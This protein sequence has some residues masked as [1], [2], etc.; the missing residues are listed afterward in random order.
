MKPKHLLFPVTDRRLGAY[1]GLLALVG[2]ERLLE[3]RRSRRNQLRSGP[4][5]GVAA[6]GG[7]APMVA[8]HCALFALPPL[9]ILALRRRPRSSVAAPALVALAGA[10]ALRLWAI[11]ALGSQWNVRGAVPVAGYA[12]SSGP[13]RFLRHPNYL[14]VAVEMAALPLVW[15]APVSALLL[16]LLNAAVLS[17]RISAEERLLQRLP[18]YLE[19]MQGKDRFLPGLF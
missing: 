5:L 17:P 6:P 13:Y 14:A 16:S 15:P 11:A 3:V 8:L 9:E 1:L 19:T 2:G 18:G 10:T 7:F 4:A 12:V